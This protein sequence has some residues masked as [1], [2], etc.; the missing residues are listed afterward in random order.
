MLLDEDGFELSGPYSAAR[1]TYSR[2]SYYRGH[3][4][5]RCIKDAQSRVPE[6]YESLSKLLDLKMSLPA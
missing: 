3:S 2:D 5:M 1:H 6:L 4:M